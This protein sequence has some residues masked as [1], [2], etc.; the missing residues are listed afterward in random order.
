MSLPGDWRPRLICDAV[1]LGN[2]HDGGYVVAARSVSATEV[3]VSLGLSD[4]WSFE[5]DFC[6]TN[7]VTR[8][9]GFDPTITRS[10]WLKRIFSHTGAA[11]FRFELD[12]VGRV[13][14]WLRFQ[15]FFDGERHEYRSIRIGYDGVRSHSLNTIFREI[16]GANIFLKIDIEGSEYRVLDQIAANA[17]RLTGLVMEFHD[18]D[19]MR[20]RITHFL[21]AVQGELVVCHLHPN[22]CA[23]V[24]A[25]GDPLAVEISLVPR[26]F[27][28]EGEC[29]E[30]EILPASLDRPNDARQPEILVSF[31][32]EN[33]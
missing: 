25:R 6:R 4:D 31:E 33:H 18:V 27:V 8:V 32:G 9:I 29:A 20:D 12:R 22:N 1:R 10:F 14:D 26:R 5:A 28:R 24:D 13:F 30:F 21:R 19:L 16:G 11:L 7:P 15:R 2:K 17:H 3:L 23:G